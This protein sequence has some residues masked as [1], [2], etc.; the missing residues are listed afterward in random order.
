[1]RV[2]AETEQRIECRTSSEYLSGARIELFVE[3]LAG[4]NDG[5]IDGEVSCSH[6]HHLYTQWRKII[7]LDPKHLTPSP[8]TLHDKL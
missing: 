4:K 5:T 1:M 8:A 6:A 3:E 7:L 2:Q